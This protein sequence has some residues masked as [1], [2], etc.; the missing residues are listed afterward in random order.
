MSLSTFVYNDY[1][2][3]NSLKDTI[4]TLTESHDKNK[5]T[6]FNTLIDNN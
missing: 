5:D 2:D 6:E 4:N 1:E 3:D